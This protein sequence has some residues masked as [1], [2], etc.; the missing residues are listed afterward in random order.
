MPYIA[1]R[2]VAELVHLVAGSS[3]IVSDRYHPAICAASLGKPAQVISNREP[4][5]M[6]GLKSLFAD[7]TLEELQELARTGLRTV[8]DAFRTTV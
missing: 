5:K 4:H 2:S 3:G 1:C 8:R 6:E 7:N